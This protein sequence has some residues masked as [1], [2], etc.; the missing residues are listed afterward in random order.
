MQ[1]LMKL[2]SIWAALG[3][4]LNSQEQ[5]QQ[6]DARSRHVLVVRR[7]G[8]VVR[9]AI[10]AHALQICEE[11]LLL[12]VMRVLKVGIN[13][14]EIC[15]EHISMSSQLRISVF[16]PSPNTGFEEVASYQLDQR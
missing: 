6:S 10:L 12:C 7:V 9:H 1:D 11:R 3:S 8:R 14:C 4:Q 5:E 15:I 13:Q 16:K 2:W